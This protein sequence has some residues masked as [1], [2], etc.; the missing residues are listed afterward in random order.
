M[1]VIYQSLKKTLSYGDAVVEKPKGLFMA[2]TCVAAI[3]VHGT[4]KHTALG[5]HVGPFGRQPLHDNMKCSL[6]NHLSD[7]KVT[8]I[9]E[10]SLASNE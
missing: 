7:L 2:P 9:D 1:K 10:I 5:I 6:R 3:Q 8:I 4:T